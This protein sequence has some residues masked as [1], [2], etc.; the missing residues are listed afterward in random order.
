MAL[1]R[2]AVADPVALAG[3]GSVAAIQAA[4]VD[5][6]K[7]LRHDLDVIVAVQTQRGWEIDRAELDE[8]LPTA[9]E[10]VCR[11]SEPARSWTAHVLDAAERDLGGLIADAFRRAHGHLGDLDELLR[12]HRAKVLLERARAAIADC[13]ALVVP[14]ARFLGRQTNYGRWALRLDG[15]GL[16]TLRHTAN[17]WSYGGGGSGRLL[18]VRGLGSR[19][20]L[21]TGPEV[22]GAALLDET[23]VPQRIRVQA[24]VGW[25]LIARF[26]RRQ[27][28]VEA[29]LTG[30][31]HMTADGDY[32]GFGTRLGCLVML[33]S[34]RWL[35]ALPAA[36]WGASIE[37]MWTG[38]AGAAGELTV[39][40]GL[41]AGFDWDFGAA[42][43]DRRAH[44]YD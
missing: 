16:A 15:G 34:L 19:L 33:G 12:V 24:F 20:A 18:F 1:A 9:L 30:L 39:R 3:E 8:M 29:D 36:G 43:R 44:G 13:P 4:D 2:P 22:G 10:S 23:E 27:Y 28:H 32:R 7:A 31:V 26:T 6:G 25:P 42:A 41:R 35:D 14:H 38:E 21:L 17:G 5:A 40:F 37:K 11:T